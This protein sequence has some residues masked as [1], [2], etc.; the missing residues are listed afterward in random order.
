MSYR[1][2][3]ARTWWVPILCHGL[4]AGCS[5]V[6]V[7]K[8]GSFAHN[9]LFPPAGEN[10]SSTSDL[11]F[12]LFCFFIW[13]PPLGWCHPRGDKGFVSCCF[14]WT[15]KTKCCP[16]LWVSTTP[17]GEIP[18][19]LVKDSDSSCG[20]TLALVKHQNCKGIKGAMTVFGTFILSNAGRRLLREIG[21]GLKF[22]L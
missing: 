17:L 16:L 3:T 20:F 10:S 14:H 15:K 13:F 22:S 11:F 12:F 19:V 7:T 8:T 1:D 18:Q 9:L 21:C 5:S 4:A 2:R 6:M